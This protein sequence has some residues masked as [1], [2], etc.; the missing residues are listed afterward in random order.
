MPGKLTSKKFAAVVAMILDLE[1]LIDGEKWLLDREAAEKWKADPWDG[2]DT[3]ICEVLPADPHPSK[4]YVASPYVVELSWLLDNLKII[5]SDFVFYGN[6]HAFYG[7]LA[8][9]ANRYL[10]QR[11]PAQQN[12]KDLC[13]AVA[14]EATRIAEEAHRGEL[15]G[16]RDEVRIKQIW[17][18][19][20]PGA[21]ED[22]A[23]L[24]VYRS[25]E[26]RGSSLANETF[27]FR[28]KTYRMGE[29]RDLTPEDEH[30]LHIAEY[31]EVLKKPG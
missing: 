3:V 23:G 17:V 5:C 29:M 13:F 16:V 21:G 30:L 11:P 22:G 4:I 7:R 24:A 1:N 27:T 12:A 18:H 8:D 10:S 6:K 25:P 15:S 28:N 2:A 9:A 19:L 31:F 26:G 20:H 14:R